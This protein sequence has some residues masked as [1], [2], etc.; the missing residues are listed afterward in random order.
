M[1]E[2]TRQ[3]IIR[4]NNTA[5]QTLEF[6]LDKVGPD[7]KDI[8]INDVLSGDLDFSILK[9]MGFREVKQI[10]F[11]KPGEVTSVVHLPSTL[12]SFRCPHQLLV[13]FD[14]ALPFLEELNLEQNHISKIDLSTLNRLK[15]LNL[16]DNQLTGSMEFQYKTPNSNVSSTSTLEFS[17]NLPKTIEELY[18]NNNEIRLIDLRNN[19]KLRVFHAVGNKMLR[20]QNVPPSIVDLQIEDN[21]MVE[22]D[23]SAMPTE[24][25]AET[26]ESMVANMDYLES[27]NQYFSM[28]TKYEDDLRLSRAT[29]LEKARSRKQRLKLIREYRPKCI[30][31]R[32]PFGTIFEQRDK[33]YI[34]RC[35]NAGDP[36]GL[37]IQLYRGNSVHSE[38]LL[39]LFHNQMESTKETIISQKL[40][41]LFNYISEKESA[42]KFK[43]QLKEY[44]IDNSI[45]KDTLNAFNE[46]HY[47]PHK[48][49]LVRN[50][51]TQIH[52]LKNTMKRMLDEYKNEENLETLH[53]IT[54]IYIHEYLPEIHNLRLLNYEVMEMISIDESCIKL[55]GETVCPGK[56]L[57]QLDVPL[58]KL[59]HLLGEPPRVIA[60]SV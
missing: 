18:I 34:A 37:N 2:E 32:R 46:L 36:C 55:E 26:P 28:K 10:H 44:S 43:K 27:L 29:L 21:P 58:S 30:K 1:I 33:R 48:R 20:I 52:E 47:S 14:N 45:Y 50:K 53:T 5:Q 12:V 8:I 4:D 39:Y 3:S 23:Y 22:L 19:D 38:S 24:E 60:F 16:N 9:T 6:L 42:E 49:E 31:C 41:T 51:I 11:T 35:G 15:V 54:D 57:F 7:V 40:D 25:N 59:E 56:Q 17:K 13:E